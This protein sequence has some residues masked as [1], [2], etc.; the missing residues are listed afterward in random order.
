[1]VEIKPLKNFGVVGHPIAHSKSPDIHKAFA[2]QFGLKIAYEKY[3]IAPSEFEAFVEKF[4]A[5]GGTGLNVTVP[6]KEIAFRISEPAN[7]R[8]RLSKAVNTLFL[9]GD[10]NLTG[11]NT[12]GPG[13]VQDLS[14]NGILIKNKSVLVLGAG[15]AVRGI[16]PSL[17]ERGCATITVANRTLKNAEQ[18]KQDFESYFALNVCEFD[19]IPAGPFDV[20]INGTSMGLSGETPNVPAAAVGKA[21]SCYDLMYSSTATAFVKWGIDN[22][23]AHAVDGL[24]MLVE[25]AA[26]SF[27]LWL[28]ETPSTGSVKDGLRGL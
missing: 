22:N 1:M 2:A 19:T 24:G 4:F 6:F 8:V 13:L 15:G 28:A 17:I 25:Q 23:A 5:E 12:D 20:I 9:S 21:T 10:G 27:K 16:L 26:E 7:D 3:D 11:E 18:L 14:E